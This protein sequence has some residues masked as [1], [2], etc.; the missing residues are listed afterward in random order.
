MCAPIS[1][2]P[3]HG[4]KAPWPTVPLVQYAGYCFSVKPVGDEGAVLLG[5]EPAPKDEEPRAHRAP[6][7]GREG[8]PV[9][10]NAACHPPVP[11][12]LQRCSACDVLGS[13]A[14]SP[15]ALP[16]A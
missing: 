5:T 3:V 15:H 1:A 6:V 11:R 16:V 9:P 8:P 4:R 12:A 13:R 7:E 2:T 10:V 14:T